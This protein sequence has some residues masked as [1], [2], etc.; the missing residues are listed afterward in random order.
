MPPVNV[1]AEGC[2]FTEFFEFLGKKITQISHNMEMLLVE[3][4]ET[5]THKMTE[6]LKTTNHRLKIIAGIFKKGKTSESASQ[7]SLKAVHGRDSLRRIQDRCSQRR[8]MDSRLRHLS[9]S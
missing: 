7:S 5:H 3:V 9:R 1:W 2:C 8:G 6:I 4:I